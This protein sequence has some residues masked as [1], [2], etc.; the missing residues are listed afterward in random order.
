MYY[1][2]S[3]FKIFS[4]YKN[5]NAPS[6]NY[7]EKNY[8]A[9]KKENILFYKK[10][11]LIIIHLESI[12]KTY[13]DKKIFSEDLIPNIENLSNENLSFSGYLQAS[14]TGWTI[15]G[16]FSAYCGVPLKAVIHANGYGRFKEFFPNIKC[17]PEILKDNDYNTYFMQGADLKFAG[18][19]KFFTQHG[20]DEVYGKYE[21]QSRSDYRETNDGDWGVNDK[22]LFEYAK[23]KL[24]K[25]SK[26]NKPFMMSL[27]TVDTHHPKGFLSEDCSANYDNRFKNVLACNDKL[28][29]S[30]IEWIKSQEF[31]QDTTIVVVGD[32]LS[33]PNLIY[34][35]LEKSNN[36]E[37]VNVFI[38]SQIETNNKNRNFTAFDLFPTIMESMG[39]KIKGDQLGLGIS[40]FSGKKT[41]VEKEG[42]RSFNSKIYRKSRLYESFR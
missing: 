28:L 22:A 9:P 37:I 6:S 27:L 42:L 25:I 5:L 7:Y 38:N 31:Y 4:Y 34:D 26:S 10:N 23:K 18:K 29:F 40:L 20:I 30:F 8:V 35:K 33:M 11:N 13:Y 16:L 17:L 24:L 15:G 12:E 14:G 36:R 2:L 41:L 19:D 3:V 21:L 39:A 1:T 32:H